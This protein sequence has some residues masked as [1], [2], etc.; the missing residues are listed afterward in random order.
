MATL[1]DNIFPQY[2]D[3]DGNPLSG[4]EIYTYTAGTSTPKETYSDE[5]AAVPNTNPVVLDAGGRAVIYIGAG[6]YKFVLKDADGNTIDTIDDVEAVDEVDIDSAWTSHAVTDAQAATN[7]SGET[8][9]GTTHKA[10]DYTY[11]IKRGTTVL[12]IGELSLLYMNSVWYLET[13]PYRS[14]SGVAH[15]VTFSISGTTT[16]QLLAALDTG[17]GNGTI[18]LSRKLIAA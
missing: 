16:V 15:G 8:V 2:L 9:V 7:L 6:A 13:G 1:L 10:A 18:Q 14:P 17:A 4:G 11:V 12:A 3:D 5:D